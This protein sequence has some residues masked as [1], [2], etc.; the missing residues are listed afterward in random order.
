MSSKRIASSAHRLVLTATPRQV[1]LRVTLPTALPS[2]PAATSLDSLK[3]SITYTPPA[4]SS[5]PKVTL[6]PSEGH[7]GVLEFRVPGNLAK[8]LARHVGTWYIEWFNNQ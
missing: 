6:H 8:S 2:A 5:K 4:K 3:L 7:F 1:T